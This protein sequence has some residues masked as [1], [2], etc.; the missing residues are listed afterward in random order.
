MRFER[1]DMDTESGILPKANATS[2]EYA[3]YWPPE[4]LALMTERDGMYVSTRRSDL[5]WAAMQG[6]TPFHRMDVLL[7]H[8]KTK[9]KC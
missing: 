1:H 4:K 3:K 9:C 7:D 8:K 5:T 2:P 6:Q